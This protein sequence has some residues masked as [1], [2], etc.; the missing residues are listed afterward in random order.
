LAVVL[1]GH[2]SAEAISSYDDAE[3]DLTSGVSQAGEGQLVARL[4]ELGTVIRKSP[5]HKV[6][7]SL[8]K[9]FT[10]RL[11]GM[12]HKQAAVEKLDADSSVAV[13]NSYL[14]A[15]EAD[16]DKVMHVIDWVKKALHSQRTDSQNQ[17][18]EKVITELRSRAADA[19]TLSRQT[20]SP[21]AM[22]L[23]KQMQHD[24][25]AAE[26]KE[27]AGEMHNDLGE[28]EDV[29][30]GRRGSSKAAKQ[31]KAAKLQARRKHKLQKEM[32]NDP[33]LI[34]LAADAKRKASKAKTSKKKLAKTVR[35]QS[36]AKKVSKDPK[37]R[38]L[39]VVAAK[40]AAHAKMLH[41]GSKA[42]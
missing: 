35:R 21:E 5:V 27:E 26:A 18:Q 1:V 10:P 20:K 3:L 31:K 11:W 6:G 17:R 37:L 42:G 12:W 34:K 28:S 7:E 29:G 8:D 23:A 40:K 30:A 15:N 38:K 2:G 33:K 39:Q 32:K 25:A 14:C 19:E 9:A 41:K 36:G 4:K 24:L 16:S 13:L 22:Q